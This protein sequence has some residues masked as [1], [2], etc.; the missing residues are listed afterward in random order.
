MTDWLS[1]S[2]PATT[3]AEWHPAP[4]LG[5]GWSKVHNQDEKLSRTGKLSPLHIQNVSLSYV[6]A[7]SSPGSLHCGRA[8]LKLGIHVPQVTRNVSCHSRTECLV[9]Y[10]CV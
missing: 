8:H 10:E 9:L 2:A 3:E 4:T 7:V 6:E 5:D 1:D